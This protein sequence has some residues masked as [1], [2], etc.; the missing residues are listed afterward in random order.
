[1]GLGASIAGFR[2]FPDHHAYSHADIEALRGWIRQQPLEA[3]VV[4]T[5]KDLVKIRL[6]RLGDRPLWALRI[7]LHLDRGQEVLDRKLQHVLGQES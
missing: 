3:V 4:T 2:A 6:C 1:V 7:R 5:Q